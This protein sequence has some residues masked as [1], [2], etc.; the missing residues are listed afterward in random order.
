MR[1]LVLVLLSFLARLLAAWAR[2]WARLAGAAGRWLAL[3]QASTEPETPENGPPADWLLRVERPAP[4]TW[5]DYVHERA[6]GVIFRRYQFSGTLPVPDLRTRPSAGAGR[7][8]GHRRV[9]DV[10][11][12][13]RSSRTSMA[14]G[15]S[16]AASEPEQAAGL[17]VSG[18]M[19]AGSGSPP[20]LPAGQKTWE[21]WRWCASALLR[22]FIR[23][24]GQSLRSARH[25]DATEGVP[26][27]PVQDSG[28]QAWE[29]LPHPPKEQQT[30]DVRPQRRE[31]ASL[32]PVL[33]QERA[34]RLHRWPAQASMAGEPQL[35]TGGGAE[36][37]AG[38]VADPWPA[39]MRLP[40]EAEETQAGAQDLDPILRSS[41]RRKRLD[42]EQRGQLWNGSIY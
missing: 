21:S 20:C 38:S 9:P 28:M 36:A 7:K 25:W 16:D 39:L 31:K 11:A 24:P 12:S 14:T 17:A 13:R 41:R 19:V 30:T 15:R 27:V 6:P 33:G 5:L 3:A 35:T 34:D 26:L 23:A 40:E 2:A 8:R 37:P 1:R 42:A 4:A 10:A 22:R 18:A 32:G 29:R